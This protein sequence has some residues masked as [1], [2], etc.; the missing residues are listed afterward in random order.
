MALA[1]VEGGVKAASYSRRRAVSCGDCLRGHGSFAQVHLG[2]A[3][4]SRRL[5]PRAVLIRRA[6]D[7]GATS[8]QMPNKTMMRLLDMNENRL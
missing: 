4:F 8:I 1:D 5:Q 3:Y 7:I 2:R 6:F